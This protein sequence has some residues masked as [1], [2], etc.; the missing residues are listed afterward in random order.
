MNFSY[1]LY[2]LLTIAMSVCLQKGSQSFLSLY[3]HHSETLQPLPM[4]NQ[5][6][7]EFCF[8]RQNLP[9]VLNQGF[10]R[11]VG[12][13]LL[14]LPHH[15]NSLYKMKSHGEQ[16][17]ATLAEATSGQPACG[18]FHSWPRRHGWA[19]CPE[20]LPGR[21]QLKLPTCRTGAGG[22]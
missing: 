16:G 15:E 14:S 10:E 6:G 11:P 7:L 5:A 1:F 4:L 3:P 18:L 12:P 9:E 19:Q 22:G 21:A 13:H 8:N 17:Q 2:K 20:E